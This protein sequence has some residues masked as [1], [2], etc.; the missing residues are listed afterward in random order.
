MLCASLRAPWRGV[1]RVAADARAV[2]RRP[3][4]RGALRA[5]LGQP[6]RALRLPS[7]PALGRPARPRPPDRPERAAD[8]RQPPRR[9]VRARARVHERARGAS[10][11]AAR[12]RR[13]PGSPARVPVPA[14]RDHRR[15]ARR[16]RAAADDRDRADRTQRGP[17]LVLLASVPADTGN[18]A[19]R[20]GAALATLRARPR[21]R[22]GDPDRR[23]RAATC[24][25]GA[26]RAPHVRRSLRA[27]RRSSV[28]A[29]RR[30]SERRAP[31]RSDVS[32]SRSSTSR[33]AATS[34]RS[35][36]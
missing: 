36:R 18:A 20:V 32:R 27:R 30:R 9:A 29:A 10:R 34:R 22:A 21:R 24:R 7:G 15:P 5:P 3:H 17:D 16:H 1:R 26:H 28:R 23:P 19:P 12:L 11:R 6:A 8:A 25:A 31:L 35:S 14:R 13:A 2:P 4:D 33:R